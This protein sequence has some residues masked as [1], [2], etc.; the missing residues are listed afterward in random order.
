MLHDMFDIE[1]EQAAR[2]IPYDGRDNDESGA[3][4]FWDLAGDVVEKLQY[5]KLEERQEILYNVFHKIREA[6]LQEA[7]RCDYDPTNGVDV[8][9][10]EHA[11]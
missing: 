6:T 3:G 5:Y 9:D 11:H 1:I 2:L 10:K 8:C 4:M 7:G